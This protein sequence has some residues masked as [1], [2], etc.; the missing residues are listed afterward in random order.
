MR[1]QT[2]V[3]TAGDLLN[4]HKQTNSGRH[5]L[6]RCTEYLRIPSSNCGDKICQPRNEPHLLCQRTL[7]C[8]VFYLRGWV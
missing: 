8:A 7:W 3:G 4:H 1:K 2:L 6:V 5:C